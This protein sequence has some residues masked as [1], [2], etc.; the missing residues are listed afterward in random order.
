MGPHSSWCNHMHVHDCG[1][2]VSLLNKQHGSHDC[3]ISRWTCPKSKLSDVAATPRIVQNSM[4]NNGKAGSGTTE[5][6]QKSSAA[7]LFDIVSGHKSLQ[8]ELTLIDSVHQSYHLP[9]IFRTPLIMSS[10]CCFKMPELTWL[11]GDICCT[12]KKIT[13]FSTFQFK[14]IPTRHVTLWIMMM[15]LVLKVYTQSPR[16]LITQS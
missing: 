1:M 9:F 7:M 11:V 4:E 5:E 8:L 12:Y 6:Q 10:Q 16:L 14:K 13:W 15:L 3:A 2:S